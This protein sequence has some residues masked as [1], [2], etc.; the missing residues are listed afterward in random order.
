LFK[1][2]PDPCPDEPRLQ[3]RDLSSLESK[4]NVPANIDEMTQSSN[5]PV[6]KTKLGK[7]GYNFRNNSE[8][9][10]WRS[11]TKCEC[12]DVYD[13]KEGKVKEEERT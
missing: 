3:D 5:C 13:R 1:T 7:N 4:K 12:A 6:Q 8:L 2:K 11:D 9:P 10:R